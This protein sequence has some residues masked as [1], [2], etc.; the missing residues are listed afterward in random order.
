MPS[1]RVHQRLEAG[2]L[3]FAWTP[4]V[5]WFLINRWVIATDAMGFGFA[6][7]FSMAFL[8]PDLDL[9]GSASYRR[10]GVLRWLWIPYASV[11][12]HR[13]LSHHLLLGPLTRVLYLG[14]LAVAGAVAVRWIRGTPLPPLPI[15]VRMAV[16]IAVGLYLPNV[17]HVCAD[18]LDAARRQ[19]L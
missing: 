15:S 5:A 17:I 16:A 11:F 10:W 14:V 1:G 12:R 2:L 8:S 18:R 19:R 13:R 6:Y 9:R 3:L 4:L 7:G